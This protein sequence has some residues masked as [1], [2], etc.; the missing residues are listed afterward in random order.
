V[1]GE[2]L[3]RLPDTTFRVLGRTYGRAPLDRFDEFG[4]IYELP[5][6]YKNAAFHPRENIVQVD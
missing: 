5:L 1:F 2:D 3:K 4:L 6:P